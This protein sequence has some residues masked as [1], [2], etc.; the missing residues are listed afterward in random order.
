MTNP[1]YLV[2]AG[3][4]PEAKEWAHNNGLPPRPGRQNGWNY[5][6]SVRCLEGNRGSTV[7][8]APGYQRRND[9]SR[10]VDTALDL[11]ATGWLKEKRDK[12]RLSDQDN[13]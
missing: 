10:V 9:L 4:L 2:I 13:T 6:T 1:Y 11:I 8:F 5:A 3:S 12:Y 7:V